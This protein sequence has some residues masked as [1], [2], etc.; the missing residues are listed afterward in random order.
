M[1]LMSILISYPYD[2]VA[3]TFSMQVKSAPAAY[4]LAR[5]KVGVIQLSRGNADDT[6]KIV[7]QVDGLLDQV[8]GVG[9]VHAEFY[10]LA[11]ENF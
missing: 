3:V 6:K 1:S 7:T 9:K 11:R 2:E 8:D 10:H 5:V 4:A